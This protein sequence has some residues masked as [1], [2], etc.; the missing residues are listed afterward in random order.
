MVHGVL[1][2]LMCIVF[3]D[4]TDSFIKDSAMH[5]NI[6]HHNMPNIHVNSTLQS[7]MTRFAIYYS[8]MGFVV[9]VAAYGQVAFWSLSAARQAT[10]I[11]KLFFHRIMQQD[12]GWFDVVETGE[13]NTRLT[14]WVADKLHFI[15]RSIIV[16]KSCN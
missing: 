1:L 4:M 15:C 6:S 5:N 16:K 7:D 13:L 9:L 12:I 11:R 10:R 14:E 3:G 8:I 2:P